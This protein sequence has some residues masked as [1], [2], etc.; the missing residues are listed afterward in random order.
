M[1]NNIPCKDAG[2]S[3]NLLQLIVSVKLYSWD[4]KSIFNA[5]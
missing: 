4:N 1:F 3:L 2:L 5:L